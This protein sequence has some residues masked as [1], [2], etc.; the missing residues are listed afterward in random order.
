MNSDD[1]I[2]ELVNGHQEMKDQNQFFNDMIEE[3]FE[4]K[5]TVSNKLQSLEELIRGL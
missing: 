2:K 5:E 4:K 1:L 3:I